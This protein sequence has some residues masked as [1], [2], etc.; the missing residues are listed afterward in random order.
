MEIVTAELCTD[1]A[2]RYCYYGVAQKHYDSTEDTTD[3]GNGNYVAIPYGGHCDHR[4]IYTGR[5]IGKRR[6]RLT[7]LDHIHHGSK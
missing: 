7:P 3:K 6:S 1:Y 5:D 2:R 4:P